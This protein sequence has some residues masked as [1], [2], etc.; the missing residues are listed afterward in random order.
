M[1]TLK[2]SRNGRFG[3]AVAIKKNGFF[4]GPLVHDLRGTR[5]TARIDESKTRNVGFVGINQGQNTRHGVQNSNLVFLQKIAQIINRFCGQ[6]IGND[7][8]CPNTVRNPSFFDK[9]IK[10]NRKA[11]IHNVIVGQF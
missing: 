11:L 9:H 5:L 7:E 8:R 6:N 3:W 2:G 10:R 4:S 1:Q